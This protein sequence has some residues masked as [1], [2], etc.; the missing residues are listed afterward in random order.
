LPSSP[1]DVA[2]SLRLDAG[3]SND[4]RRIADGAAA[5]LA[6]LHARERSAPALL[7]LALIAVRVVAA[8]IE[9]IPEFLYD[10]P[11]QTSICSPACGRSTGWYPRSCTALMETLH[12]ATLDDSAVRWRAR[13]ALV[14]QHHALRRSQ[15]HRA[16]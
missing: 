3:C 14:A 11:Q 5:A 4:D 13:R 2:R 12:T 10:A 9:I 7:S 6:T 8:T 16:D 15:R 1:C